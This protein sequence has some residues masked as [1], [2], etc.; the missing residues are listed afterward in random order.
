[1]TRPLCDTI[2]CCC[3]TFQFWINNQYIF[4]HKSSTPRENVSL[5]RI[6]YFVLAYNFPNYSVKPHLNLY[7][8]IHCGTN[9]QY[10]TVWQPASL[11]VL[12]LCHL[13]STRQLCIC[14]HVCLCIGMSVG[15]LFCTLHFF[16]MGLKVAV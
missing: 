12:C 8:Q 4:S 16:C 14:M 5:E 9:S 2:D 1:M 11:S 15:V 13:Q 10:R 6:T 7:S 3:L